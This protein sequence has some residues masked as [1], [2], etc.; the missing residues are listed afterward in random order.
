MDISK[1]WAGMSLTSRRKF[2]REMRGIL[3]SERA[4]E[5]SKAK[6]ALYM[7]G[8][9]GRWPFWLKGW[10]KRGKELDIAFDVSGRF[11]PLGL[12]HAGPAQD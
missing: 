10:K 5:R 11:H 12:P 8:T 6:A 3:V 2:L 4:E 1:E 9:S 7:R